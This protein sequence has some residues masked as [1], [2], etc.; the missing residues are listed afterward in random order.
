[1]MSL[2][3][4]GLWTAMADGDS[5]MARGDY[6]AAIEMY[7]AEVAADSEAYE[8]KFQLARALSFSGG[9]DEAI[10]IY[11]EL[12]A[13]RPENTDLL[14]ARGRVL[15]WQRRYPEAEADLTAVT[16]LSPEYGDAWSALGDMYVWSDRPE[17]AVEAYGRWQEVRPDSPEAYIARGRAWRSAGNYAAARA[18]FTAAGTHG[19]PAGEVE[20]L[21][22]T[23]EIRRAAQESVAPE[24]YDWSVGGVWGI[25]NF[26][27]QRDEWQTATAR[28]RRYFERGSLAVEYLWAD[29]FRRSDDA[30]ALDGYVDLW[31]RAYANV[32]YQYAPDAILFPDHAYRFELY[33]G[34]GKGWEPSASY[35][36][37][38]FGDNDVDMYGAGLG[39]YVGNWYLRWRTLFIPA[40][41]ALGLSHRAMARYYFSGDAD[42]YFEV[43][44][45]WSRGGEFYRGST[46]DVE[47]TR[48]ESFGAAYQKYFNSR[49]GLSLSAGYSDERSAFIER[50]ITVGLTTR[51]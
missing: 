15:A 35:D 23:L 37:M 1:M 44:G 8:A 24:G 10:R 18:D 7:R 9:R 39:K 5:A 28:A 41:A 4:I 6:A 17:K 36:H 12:L 31:S 43:N 21:L 25:S 29:R 3:V 30:F 33:Q 46:T 48:S 50:N 38:D 11:T 42:D 27:P 14:L 51:W 2:L 22:A 45:G 16:R 34:M 47:K 40:T 26:T 13:A 20:E 49:W 32:R 19:A